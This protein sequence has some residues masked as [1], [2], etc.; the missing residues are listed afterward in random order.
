MGEDVFLSN[1]FARF[2]GIT[3]IIVLATFVLTA[4]TPQLPLP[5][6]VRRV[7]KSLPPKQER[8]VSSRVTPS[9]IMTTVLGSLMIGMLFARSL[10]YQFYAYIAWATPFIMWKAQDNP[11]WIYLVW[12]AQE[13]G[14]NVFPSTEISSKVV[15]AT[16]FIQVFGLWIG[17]TFLS[18]KLQVEP[19]ER[20]KREHIE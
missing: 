4:W 13:W 7:F 14:W 10:H 20:A 18:A 1:N 16:L 3:H 5:L 19:E 9:Y 11:L 6:L 17:T 8:E 12:A 15:V 2:L